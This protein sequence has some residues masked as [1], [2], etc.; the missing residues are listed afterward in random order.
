VPVLLTANYKTN[1]NRPT[2]ATFRV[3]GLAAF[4]D[5][6]VVFGSS[7]AVPDHYDDLTVLFQFTMQYAA[8]FNW[9][10]SVDG[11]GISCTMEV[12]A[13][14]PSFNGTDI[15]LCLFRNS[16][17]GAINEVPAAVFGPVSQDALA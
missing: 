10:R 3:S 11:N 6:A 2:L 7:S 16:N 1:S 9:I 15:Y 17:P 4:F 14:D 13:A 12:P 8:Q 5:G